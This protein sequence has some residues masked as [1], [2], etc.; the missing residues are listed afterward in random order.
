MVPRSCGLCWGVAAG[1]ALAGWHR[2]HL[3]HTIA[4]EELRG[5]A[6]TK[7]KVIEESLEL[8]LVGTYEPLVL[9]LV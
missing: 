7:L 5:F 6:V 8:L 9:S 2:Q 4:A 3:R 1:T